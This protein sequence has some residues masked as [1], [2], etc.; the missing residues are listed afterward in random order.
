MEGERPFCLACADLDHLEFLPSGDAALTRR[1]RKYSGLCA[2]VV[3]FSRSRGRYERQGLMVESA[4]LERA[5]GEAGR[6]RRRIAQ[7]VEGLGKAEEVMDRLR[8]LGQG[9]PRALRLPVSRDAQ[10]GP[11]PRNSRDRPPLAMVFV[12][13]DRVHGA[14]VPH[15]QDR[16]MY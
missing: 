11:R 8:P 10:D 4:A 15:E 6:A 14:A 13:Y 9:E 2:V 5:A 16:R 1:S 12:L 7:A 3:R